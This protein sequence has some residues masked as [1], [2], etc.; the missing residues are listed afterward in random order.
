MPRYLYENCAQQAGNTRVAI[1]VH[2]IRAA[3]LVQL[4]MPI[5]CTTSSSMHTVV[6]GADSSS[7]LLSCIAAAAALSEHIAALTCQSD[8]LSTD[9]SLSLCAVIF[10][11]VLE[12][13]VYL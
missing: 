2:P 4:Q 9:C 8:S 6:H 5:S 1:N 12:A 11:H 10:Y 7:A 3:S 13:R